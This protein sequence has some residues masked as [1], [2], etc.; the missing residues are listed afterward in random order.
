MAKKYKVA[1]AGLGYVGMSLATLLARKHQ[2]VAF[3]I[4]PERIETVNSGRSTVADPE[5]DNVLEKKT[6]ELS[7]TL[8]AAEAFS[9]ADFIIV[10]APTNY[11]SQEHY[12]DTKAVESVIKQ[13]RQHNKTAL[14]VIKS[15]IPVGFTAQ[16][17][18]ALGDDRIAFSPE[19]LREG[20]ALYDNLYPSRIIVG[21]K[22]GDAVQFAEMLRDASLNPQVDILLT[23]SNEAEAVKLFANTYLA[24]RIAFFNELDSFGLAQG[25]NVKEIIEGVCLDPRIGGGYN[26]PSFGYG[27]YCLP[28]D[29][30][31]LLANYRNIPHQLVQA[32]VESNSSR[33][34]YIAEQIVNLGAETLG[35][36]RLTMKQGSDNMRSSAMHDIVKRLLA[37]GARVIVY[38]P[39]LKEDQLAG[40]E[41][42][43]DLT[44]FLQRSDVVIC[45][46]RDK[47]LEN[48]TGSVFTR[49]IFGVD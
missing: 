10:A 12:F 31:Q 42:V 19:F 45:N 22:S 41:I 30:K 43:E 34:D 49:D 4:D 27:G 15:T 28:K 33:K 21:S 32:V 48:F 11:D 26:N 16:Q 24:T 2:V 13:A 37:E 40:V 18:Q 9:D 47:N 5:I 3:D 25:M 44:E 7:A 1:V 39:M 38:E 46:R 14:I 35:V 20:K 23:G 8:N 17:R 6:L 29:T 36:Y